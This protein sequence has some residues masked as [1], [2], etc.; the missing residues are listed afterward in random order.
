M[1]EIILASGLL[2]LLLAV[3]I[4][5]V[6]FLKIN[7]QNSILNAKNEELSLKIQ[8]NNEKLSTY[9]QIKEE[10]ANLKA[11]LQSTKENLLKNQQDYEN[12]LNKLEKNYKEL[13]YFLEE[14]LKQDYEKNSQLIYE[15]NTKIL[16]EKSNQKLNDIFE[17]IAKKLN[18]YEVNLKLQNQNIENNLK[19][20]F[21]ASMNLG[22][23]AD[24]FAAILKGDKKIRG[25]FAEEALRQVLLAS[26]LI[27]N[28]QFFLQEHFIDDENKR[29]IPDAIVYFEP[30]KC[31][32]IDSKFS[33]AFSEDENN[34]KEEL[35]K[36]LLA[37]I[38]ELAKKDYAKTIKG[39]NEYMLLF[40]PYNSLLEQACTY[41]KSLFLKA[42]KKKI[43][44]VSPSTLF[45]GLKMIYLGWNNYKSNKNLEEIMK[46]LSSFYDKF[47]DFLSDYQRLKMQID[48]GL[49][50]IDVKLY[51]RANLFSKLE[52]IQSLGIQNTKTLL[53]NKSINITHYE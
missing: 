28:E 44:L 26:G 30:E 36:N 32:V 46:E 6:K 34:F 21:D 3:S 12:N 39:A 5:F 10:N 49:S 11:Y 31:V 40:V 4:V 35:V 14:K 20:M 16:L 13:A 15:T 33:L 8:E 42:Q 17:P 37:R 23:K 41:D 47:A 9:E 38:D 18:D 1:I 22:K 19:T 7:T 48:K 25:N 53:E 52:K 45:I 29:K 51:G 43:F 50:S 2:F 24:E 27:E